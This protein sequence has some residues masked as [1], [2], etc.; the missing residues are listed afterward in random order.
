M[1]EVT[2]GG[3]VLAS[4]SDNCPFPPEP[5]V[6]GR[7]VRVEASSGLVIID[8]ALLDCLEQRPRDLYMDG[9]RLDWDASGRVFVSTSGELSQALG[10]AQGD[11]LLDVNGHPLDS[12]LGTA[13][14]YDELRCAEQVELSLLR[15]DQMLVSTYV[16]E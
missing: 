4:P 2:L 11:V 3:V 9:T 1:C 16:I 15:E 12:I 8:S 13:A 6:P 7:H 5:W 10:L 14:L